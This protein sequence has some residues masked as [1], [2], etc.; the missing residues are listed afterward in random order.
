[1]H[2]LLDGG[3]NDAPCVVEAQSPK[4]DVLP[5]K[6]RKSLNIRHIVISCFILLCVF[7]A[8]ILVGLSVTAEKP[9][10]DITPI[11]ALNC[12]D[13]SADEAVGTFTIEW[14]P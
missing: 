12:E 4:T 1:M 14:G 8:G 3:E 5:E 9:E 11:S 6:K 13:D 7:A 10:K 2:E